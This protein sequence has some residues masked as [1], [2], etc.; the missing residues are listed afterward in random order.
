MGNG[1]WPTNPDAFML[2]PTH[3]RAAANECEAALRQA[4]PSWH[5]RASL[6]AVL[7]ALEEQSDLIGA[8]TPEHA[9]QAKEIGRLQCRLLEAKAAL[10]EAAQAVALKAAR[11]ALVSIRDLRA[12]YSRDRLVRAESAVAEAQRIATEALAEVA[13]G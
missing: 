7:D 5:L 9:A 4:V 13:D 2:P 1:N 10:P 3:A 8:L 6:R 11:A 12:P